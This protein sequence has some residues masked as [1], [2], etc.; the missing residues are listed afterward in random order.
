MTTRKTATRAKRIGYR[1]NVTEFAENYRDNKDSHAVVKAASAR[2]AAELHIKA[3]RRLGLG[4]EI[5]PVGGF[6][7][8]WSDVNGDG[9]DM[10][11][12]R[13][14]DATGLTHRL[15]VRPESMY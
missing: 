2:E 11:I 12:G 15:Y 5:Q 3:M 4:D 13:S 1:V 10:S 7:R 6:A 8:T 14:A 9:C